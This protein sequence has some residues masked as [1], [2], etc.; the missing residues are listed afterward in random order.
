MTTLLLTG[1]NKGEDPYA[2]SMRNVLKTFTKL[3]PLLKYLFLDCN[4]NINRTLQNDILFI[5][6]RPIS[7]QI[8]VATQCLIQILYKNSKMYDFTGPEG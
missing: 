3:Y 1:H 8:L 5:L 7:I 6:T 4:M 2:V